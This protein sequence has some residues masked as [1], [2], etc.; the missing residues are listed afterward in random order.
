MPIGFQ[1]KNTKKGGRYMPKT[2]V[3]DL[4]RY[5]SDAET[6]NDQLS[7]LLADPGFKTFAENAKGI[8]PKGAILT[9]KGRLRDYVQII[10]AALSAA[11]IEWPPK[12]NT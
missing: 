9:A 5:R 4:I 2:K 6:A 3:S 12:P 11:E 1:N 8:D 7:D 10:D